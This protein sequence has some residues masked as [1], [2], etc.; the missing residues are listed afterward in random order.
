MTYFISFS[1]LN[2]FFLKI[3]SVT[4]LLNKIGD[5][6]Y[7]V[8]EVERDVFPILINDKFI[9]GLLVYAIAGSVGGL[10]YSFIFGN[11]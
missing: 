11:S 10:L 4:Y 1:W 7:E 6:F 3:G 5:N 9:G 8:I 2:Q